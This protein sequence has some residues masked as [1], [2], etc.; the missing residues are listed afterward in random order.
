MPIT[1][2]PPGGL[3]SAIAPEAW[4]A[5][6]LEH[7]NA[8]SVVLASGATRIT[9]AQRIIHVPRI[10]ADGSAAW[11]SELEEIGAGDPTGDELIM[12]PKKVAALTKLSDEVVTDS[13]PSVLDAVGTSMTRAVALVA[14]RAFLGGAGGKAPLGV[15]GQAGQHVAGPID[16][17]HLI[18]AAGLVS[19]VGGAARVAYVNPADFTAL[20]KA[21]DLQDRPL[22]TPDFSGGPSS[23]VYGLA[24]WATK[25][26][27]AGTA[28]VCDPA[29]IV[30]CVR[31]DP[32]VAV[33]TDA[34]FTQDGAVCRVIARVDCGVNDPN[35]LVSIAA[36]AGTQSTEST[37]STE[38][39][40]GT[41]G[42][43]K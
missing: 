30:V 15:F 29:Q 20:Q 36:T 10:T 27:A 5:Y 40:G 13:S 38:S 39:E 24:L 35:G 22:L 18:D 9:T 34:L 23:T 14:D 6:L 21:K 41:R 32:T 8:Q 7:L 28:L 19:D 4:A 16:I 43:R 11:Y 1:E 26:V 2:V 33:S 3:G 37:E 25:G 31:S 17:D 42:R 12:Q